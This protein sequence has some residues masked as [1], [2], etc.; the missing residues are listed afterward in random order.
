MG[1]AGLVCGRCGTV[2]FAAPPPEAHAGSACYLPVLNAA[3]VLLTAGGNVPPDRAARLMGMLLGAEV[4]AGWVDNAG[5]R[6]SALPG[7]AGLEEAMLA[8]LA[9]EQAV[10]AGE[11]R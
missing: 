7:R 6:L 3:A 5:A 8:A 10:A 11:T 9:G 2:T 1:V 4:S